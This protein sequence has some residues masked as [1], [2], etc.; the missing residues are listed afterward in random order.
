MLYATTNRHVSCRKGRSKSNYQNIIKRTTIPEVDEFCEYPHCIA[1]IQR[2]FI[3][4]K[5]RW[6]KGQY[7]YRRVIVEKLDNTNNVDAFNWFEG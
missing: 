1:R 4:T 6:F 7:P 2:Q 5:G 3:V